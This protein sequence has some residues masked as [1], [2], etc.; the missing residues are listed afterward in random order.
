VTKGV[1]ITISLQENGK[2][3]KSGAPQADLVMTLWC[4]ETAQIIM[5]VKPPL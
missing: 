5:N 3:Q 1:A 2:V 4:L